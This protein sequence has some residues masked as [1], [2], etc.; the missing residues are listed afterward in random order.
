MPEQKQMPKRLLQ[1]LK[2]RMAPEDIP[3][4][5]IQRI[6]GDG[7]TAVTYEVVDRNGL[8]WALKLVFKDSYG[9]RAPFREIGRFAKARDERFSAF[10]K[11]TGDWDL[12][13]GNRN[14]EFVWFKSRCVRGQSLEAFLASNTDFDATVEVTRYVQNVTVALEEL[15]F[16]G[17]SHGDLHGRNIMREVVGE[18][19]I[20][21]EIRYVL[22]DFSEAHAVEE[23]QE[24]LSKDI[25]EFG[26]HLRAFYDAICRREAISREDEK[27]LGAVSHIPGLLNG[28]APESMAIS[29]PS[30]VLDRFREALRPTEEAPTSLIDPFYPFSAEYIANEAL[31]TDLCFMDVWWA[32]KL[33]ENSNVLLI[34]PRGCGKTMIFRRLRLRTKAVAGKKDEITADQYLGFY[35]P[36]ESIFFMRFAD[37][38]EVDIEA[39]KDALLL[40]FNMAILSEVSSALSCASDA[41]GPVSQSVSMLR[42]LLEEQIGVLWHELRFPSSVVNL[43]ELGT[44]AE[45]VM[46]HIR[47]SLAFGVHIHPTA[48]LDFVARLVRV[49]KDQIPSL[50]DRHFIFFLDDYTEER[51]PTRL[52]EVLHPTVCQRSSDM[53][54]KL[55]AHMFGSI[56]NVQRPLALDEGRNIEVI[57]LGTAY[58]NRNMRRVE[59]RILVKILDARLKHSAK[60]RGTIREWLG[61]T[62]Y[63]GGRT[64]SRALHDSDTRSK[65]KYHGLKCIMDLCTGDY[66]EMIRLVGNIFREANLEPGSAVRRIDPA[67][68]SRAIEKASREYL[69]RIRH[70]R[71]DGQKLYN[72][73]NC[74]GQLSRNLLYEHPLVRQ[75]KDSRGRVR[76]DPYDLLNIYVDNVMSASKAARRVW[77]RLQKASIFVDTGVA[78]SQRSMVADRATLRRI[79]CPA[80]RTTLTSSEHLQL[81]KDQFEWF[82]DKPEEF[83]K[84]C[85]ENVAAMTAP[86]LAL[87]AQAD[88]ALTE[89]QQQYEYI[90]SQCFPEDRDKVDLVGNA[91]SDWAK[92]VA[93]LPELVPLEN[94]IA[95]NSRFDVYLGAMG[96]EERTAEAP[97]LLAR[98][99]IRVEK[100]FLFEFDMYYTATAKRRESYER[101]VEQITFGKPYRPINAP[102]SVPDPIFSERLTDTLATASVS[103]PIKILFDVT[104]CPSL[105][106]SQTLTHL[107][108]S[109]CDVTIMY[110]EAADY[111]PAKDEW[112][113]GK[114]RPFGTMVQGPF[115]GVRFV[116]RPPGLQADDLGELPVLLVLFPTFNTERTAGVLADLEPAE[117]IWLIGE[118]HDLARNCYRIDMA[119]AFAA[120]NIHPGDQWSLLT[121]FDYRKTL[122]ALA[123]IYEDRR[124]R[125][126][127]VI[128]PHGSKMQ[129]LGVSLFSSVHQASQVFATPKTYNPDRYSSGCVQVWGLSLGHTKSLV[130][131]IRASRA[132]GNGGVQ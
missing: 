68:Q 81:T 6:L 48:T 28:T 72:I 57:N 108:D 82:M 24:G 33:T 12:Q 34:G 60:Y 42:K 126:R 39:K 14:Y 95:E 96:F 116:A 64:V 49:L 3:G 43:D 61:D 80:F 107:L 97:A 50:S 36:C 102:V 98:K 106:M 101:A 22:I 77:E 5:T 15:H 4:F 124:F 51:V 62:S 30:H 47:K 105:I 87:W 44:L 93:S 8:P 13:L 45:S 74:F 19:G 118:P 38:T 54:F 117:R 11:E 103:G 40:F 129:T 130:R 127:I 121:T 53:C 84:H 7:N 91:P 86:Q 88:T 73:V 111:Y 131:R 94:V 69:S 56:Y 32:S 79:Y 21:P 41:L 100:A 17:F 46:R 128:M 58:L 71:P 110:S 112:E 52:Q 18:Q 31:L 119:K 67:I 83:Y 59:S 120:P 29:R 123:S 89:E 35:I 114:V 55:S 115:A 20:F 37:L 109:D 26:R 122:L 23:A 99:G 92:V 2:S 75:G 85:R 63:P 78:T 65:V 132:I 16:L 25:E 9:N 27:L 104:S 70:I 90:P 10:P 113:S 66:S 76:E 125:Y 1:H